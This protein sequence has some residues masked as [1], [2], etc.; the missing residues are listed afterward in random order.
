MNKSYILKKSYEIENLLKNKKS[1]GSRFYVI[2]YKQN[3]TQHVHIAVSA[4]K[5]LGDAV[6]RNYEKRVIKEILR[7]HIEK[8]KGFDMLFVIKSNSLDLE[9]CEKEK[10]IKYLIK[11]MTVKGEN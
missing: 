11:K 9:F 10:Q 4:S 2:Y 7:S 5:K 6:V 1:V 8:L 3:N